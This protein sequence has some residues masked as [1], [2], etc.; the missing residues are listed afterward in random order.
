M[1]SSYA[2]SLTPVDAHSGRCTWRRT[3]RAHAQRSPR[4]S[5]RTTRRRAVRWRQRPCP[6]VPLLPRCRSCRGACRSRCRPGETKNDATEPIGDEVEPGG[7]GSL[8]TIE[9]RVDDLRVALKGEDQRD[10]DADALGQCLADRGQALDGGRNLDEQVRSVDHPPQRASLGDRLRG[11]A[12]NARVDLDRHAAV[13]SAARVVGRPQH[14]A[15]PPHV[16]GGD[17]PQRLADVDPAGR[18]VV[19]LVT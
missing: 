14:V 15:A 11:V 7:S 3:P 5:L 4:N 6:A 17:E 16:G 8:E 18:E 10:V 19:E 13:D 2:G 9:E 1:V 12:G